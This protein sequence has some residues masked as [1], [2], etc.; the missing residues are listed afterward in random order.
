M[1]TFRIDYLIKTPKVEKLSL[2]PMRNPTR[3]DAQTERF[4]CFF[5]LPSRNSVQPDEVA[6]GRHYLSPKSK[7]MAQIL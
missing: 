4:A 1:E 3:R 7:I 5:A 6:V 2:Q